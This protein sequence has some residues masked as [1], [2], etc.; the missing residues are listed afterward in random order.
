MNASRG[1]RV[2]EN[3]DSQVAASVDSG[4]SVT[5][6][7][8]ALLGIR[9][10]RYG[11]FVGS[12]HDGGQA[13]AR[14]RLE[15]ARAA[16]LR[17]CQE[18]DSGSRKR[19]DTVTRVRVSQNAKSRGWIQPAPSSVRSCDTCHISSPLSDSCLVPGEAL[20]E[21]SHQAGESF[22]HLAQPIPCLL[23][24]PGESNSAQR[25]DGLRERPNRIAGREGGH[26]I[27]VYSVVDGRIVSAKPQKCEGV[28]ERGV[29]FLR[30]GR[31]NPH[32]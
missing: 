28:G 2:P 22:G 12:V 14:I 23:L 18:T 11:C 32:L 7:P 21:S 17:S 6:H 27:Y 20:E 8:C 26:A 31:N 29:G 5:V 13:A 15:E 9:D 24:G 19:D 4:I 3:T 1:A 30:D 16:A 10:S 25:W